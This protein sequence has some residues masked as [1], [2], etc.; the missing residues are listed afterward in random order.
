MQ[1]FQRKWNSSVT[2]AAS[3]SFLLVSLEF[4]VTWWEDRICAGD[5]GHKISLQIRTQTPIL[6]PSRREWISAVQQIWIGIVILFRSSI[7]P[8]SFSVS[9]V[10]INQRFMRDTLFL[11]EQ[12]LVMRLFAVPFREEIWGHT[13]QWQYYA[14]WLLRSKWQQIPL[15]INYQ[16]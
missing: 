2:Q 3:R 11:C 6:L 9:N 7:V 15:I 16:G 1:R 13:S 10:W 14:T 8:L 12:V 4:D 5:E